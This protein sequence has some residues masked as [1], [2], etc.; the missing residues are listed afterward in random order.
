M[1][2]IEIFKLS[3]K[4]G[5]RLIHLFNIPLGFHQGFYFINFAHARSKFPFAGALSDLSLS[6]GPASAGIS[7]AFI[8]LPSLFTHLVQLVYKV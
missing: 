7:S 5:N 4:Q 8:F 3:L 2:L 6:S 1:N